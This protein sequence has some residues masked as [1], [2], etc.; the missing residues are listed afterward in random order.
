MNRSSRNDT[1]KSLPDMT[2]RERRDRATPTI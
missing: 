1:L 2:Q